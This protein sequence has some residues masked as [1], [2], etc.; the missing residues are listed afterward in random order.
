VE[1]GSAYGIYSGVNT[2]SIERDGFGK[3][4]GAPWGPDVAYGPGDVGFR[5]GKWM[6]LI[7][8]YARSFE[9]FVCPLD[10]RF[11]AQM[12]RDGYVNNGITSGFNPVAL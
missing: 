3:T 5:H 8:E 9:I 6:D 2:A 7:Y 1:P 4:P 12:P 11:Y 10:E